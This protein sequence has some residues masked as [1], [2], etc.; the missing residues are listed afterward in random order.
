[1]C[2]CAH[3]CVFIYVHCMCLHVCACLHVFMYMFRRG[4]S[5]AV[6]LS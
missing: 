6:V 4:G 1:M 2:V 5:N 3:M